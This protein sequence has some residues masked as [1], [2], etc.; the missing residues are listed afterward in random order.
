MD[1]REEISLG[2]SREKEVRKDGGVGVSNNNTQNTGGGYQSS[3]RNVIEVPNAM[4]GLTLES[5]AWLIPDPRKPEKAELVHDNPEDPWVTHFI[6]VLAWQFLYSYSSN[7]TVGALAWGNQC[8]GNDNNLYTLPANY[9]FSWSATDPTGF[10]P[11]C[12]G[13]GNNAVLIT[14]CKLYAPLASGMNA[15]QLQYLNPTWI[16]SMRGNRT[17]VYNDTQRVTIIN[18]PFVNLS[19]G[20]IVVN[21]IGLMTHLPNAIVP[22]ISFL[23]ARDVIA[24]GVSIPDGSAMVAE[25]RIVLTA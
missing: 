7:T 1:I 3:Q 2:M 23:A 24:G 18:R 17:G 16:M 6:Q 15:N 10:G 12:V 19:G 13:T 20:T 8:R 25:Y 22:N 9:S 4:R 14:D 11:I 5:S 21:E